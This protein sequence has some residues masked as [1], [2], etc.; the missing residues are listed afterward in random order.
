MIAIPKKGR[1][2]WYV[3]DFWEAF[4]TI[5][6]TVKWRKGKYT[7]IWHLGG[8]INH[9]YYRASPCDIYK[10]RKQAE[11]EAKKRNKEAKRT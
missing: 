1:V 2:Y 3:T 4:Y 8:G 9:I 10:K 5:P 7:A 11:R 6:V